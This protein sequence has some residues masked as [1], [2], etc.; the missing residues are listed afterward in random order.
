MKSTYKAPKGQKPGADVKSF[1]G[2]AMS[3][4]AKVPKSS[5]SNLMKGATS[6][7]PCKGS[8]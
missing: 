3:K 2:A 4:G 7:R 1:P 6:N 8:M 5:S